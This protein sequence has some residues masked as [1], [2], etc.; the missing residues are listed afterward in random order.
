[1]TGMRFPPQS[2]FILLL[3]R[4]AGGLQLRASLYDN[5]SGWWLYITV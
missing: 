3:S 5:I 1:M 4:F 2:M